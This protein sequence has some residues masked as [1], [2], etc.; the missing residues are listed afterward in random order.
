MYIYPQATLRYVSGEGGTSTATTINSDFGYSSQVN[1]LA[2]NVSIFYVDN[3]SL[4]P[5]N[6]LS[7]SG[8]SQN[9]VYPNCYYTK[10][11]GRTVYFGQN[12]GAMGDG[13]FGRVPASSIASLPRLEW[14]V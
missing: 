7:S 2:R 1:D 11:N 9:T 8:A 10:T 5:G 3:S 13:S 14:I 6:I 12:L 4:T